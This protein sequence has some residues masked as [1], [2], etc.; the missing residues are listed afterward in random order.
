[1]P[2]FRLGVINSES[3]RSKECDIANSEQ[4]LSS[5]QI[6]NLIDLQLKCYLLKSKI[7]K[8]T[9]FSMLSFELNTANSLQTMNRVGFICLISNLKIEHGSFHKQSNFD[10]FVLNTE[11]LQ[12]LFDTKHTYKLFVVFLFY[13]IL[14]K[15]LKNVNF[16]TPN[17][18]LYLFFVCKIFWFNFLKCFT[19]I[20]LV[21]LINYK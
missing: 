9:K 10:F 21:Q 15:L 18:Y 2:E 3:I 20:K 14:K 16:S 11:K 6:M 7:F 13:S 12:N 5:K 17:F 1:L 8:I 4:K 19:L